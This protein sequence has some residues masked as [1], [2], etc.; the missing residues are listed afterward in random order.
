M[1]LWL[2]LLIG[3][4]VLLIAV[5]A[6]W[7]YAHRDPERNIKPFH[8]WLCPADGTV[9]DIYDVSGSKTQKIK[10]KRHGITAFLDDF[11]KAS[12]VV[13]IMMKPWHVHVQRAPATCTVQAIT[14]K[15]GSFANAVLGDYRKATVE[16]E[17]AAFT[18]SGKHPSKVYL[19]AG[20][21]ARRINVWRKQGDKLKQGE[22]IGNIAFGSQV[23]IVLPKSEILVKVGD[24]VTAGVTKLAQ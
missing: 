1:E 16:N 12:S 17:H 3:F 20:L 24:R 2:G 5:V 23:A 7:L 14:Y 22:R 6:G 10:K 8:G 4:V 15:R 13:V 18:L 11:P 19:I 9:C 21:V